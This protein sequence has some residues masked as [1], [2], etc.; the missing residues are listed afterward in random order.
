VAGEG[1]V[2]RRDSAGVGWTLLHHP[3]GRHCHGHLQRIRCV[4][5]RCRC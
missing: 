2:R 5:V 1:G 4:H 3:A